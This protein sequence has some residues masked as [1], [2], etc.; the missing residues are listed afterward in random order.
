MLAADTNPR[1]NERAM[2]LKAS[3]S[4]S[5]VATKARVHPCKSQRDCFQRVFKGQLGSYKLTVSTAASRFAG[6]SVVGRTQ[7][8]AHAV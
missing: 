2:I 7:L 1:N 3:G 5:R 8:F 6:W 4:V